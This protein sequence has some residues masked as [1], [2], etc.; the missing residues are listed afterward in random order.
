M[1]GE[2]AGIDA[3]LGEKTGEEM[4]EAEGSGG[5]GAEEERDVESSGRFSEY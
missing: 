2:V 1:R 3:P 4:D 5:G